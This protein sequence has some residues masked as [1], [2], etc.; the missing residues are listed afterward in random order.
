MTTHSTLRAANIARQ[1]EWDPAGSL[2]LTFRSTELAGEVG[3]ACN[4]VKK[5]ERER[6]GIAGSRATKEQLAEELADVVICTDLI[7]MA[8]GIDLNEAIAAKF[9]ATSEKVGLSTR[10]A[11]DDQDLVDMANVGQSL[12]NAIDVYTKAPSLIEDWSPADDPAEIVG[13]LYNRFEESINCHR[14]DLDRLKAAKAALA[15]VDTYDR[16][17]RDVLNAILA[18]NKDA[19]AG[20]AALH[21][22]EADPHGKLPFDVVYWVTF[23]AGQLGI[24]ERSEDGA[25][26]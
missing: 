9:N 17:R 7:A 16:G 3:E 26:A 13:D 12:M 15:G 14:A 8:E 22:R 24:T 23:V 2:S 18:L 20:L 1:K 5:I 11:S 21:G 25:D 10:L 19:A 4:V 6:L